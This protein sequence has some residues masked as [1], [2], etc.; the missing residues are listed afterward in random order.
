MLEVFNV[1]N[2]ENYGSYATNEANAQLRAAEREHERRVSAAHGQL[3]FRVSV[4]STSQD[5]S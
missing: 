2:H 5:G 4:L 1:F 3:G